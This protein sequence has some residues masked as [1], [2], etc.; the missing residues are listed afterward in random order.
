MMLI[1]MRHITQ[2][3]KMTLDLLVSNHTMCT[4]LEPGS[5]TQK[6]HPRKKLQSENLSEVVIPY[7]WVEVKSKLRG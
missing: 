1:G 3:C 6:I 7:L 5:Y 4:M 2:S